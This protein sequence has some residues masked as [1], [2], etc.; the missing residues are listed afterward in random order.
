MACWEKVKLLD[1]YHSALERYM[2]SVSVLAAKIKTAT[3]ADYDRLV[4]SS[5]HL[6]QESEGADEFRTARQEASVLIPVVNGRRQVET[7]PRRFLLRMS[8]GR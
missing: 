1:E 7:G 5:E 2:D 3:R 8:S 6:R 4:C